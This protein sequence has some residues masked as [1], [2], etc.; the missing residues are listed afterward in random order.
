MSDQRDH[1][2]RRRRRWLRTALAGLLALAAC[3]LVTWLFVVPE[4][5]RQRIDRILGTIEPGQRTFRLGSIDPSSLNVTHVALG[6]R[7]WLTI[8]RIQARY[9][10]A[11]LWRGELLAVEVHEPVWRIA[12]H[13]GGIDWGFTPPAQGASGPVAAPFH[14]LSVREGEV[15]VESDGRVLTAPVTV[16]AAR[17]G[18]GDFRGQVET[19]EI[20]V[21]RHALPPIVAAFAFDG[22]LLD[23]TAAWA[24]FAEAP[25]TGRAQLDLSGPHPA[26]SVEVHQPTVALAERSTLQDLVPALRDVAIAGRFALDAEIRLAGGRMHPLVSLR[27][28]EVMLASDDWPIA[29]AS[30]SGILDFD[31]LAPLS[32]SGPQRIRI[33]SATTG[34]LE[35]TAGQIDFNL[36][37]P[38][39]LRIDR[40]Q[41]VMSDGGRFE[42]AAFTLDPRQPRIVTSIACD[43]VDLSF[44]LDFLTRERADGEG[45]LRGSFD[46]D[47]NPQSNPR[48]QFTGGALAA[49]PPHGFIRV[50]D[51]PALGELLEQADA[52]F[53]IDETMQRVKE[54]IVEALQDLGYTSLRFVFIPDGPGTTLQAEIKGRGRTGQRQEFEGLVV[55]FR[56]FAHQLQYALGAQ[57]A[58]DSVRDLRDETSRSRPPAIGSPLP[59]SP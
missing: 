12:A 17:A 52:R 37:S 44:W 42:A 47:W 31:A 13:D 6:R 1:P 19:G 2:P 59:D 57:A 29:I 24:L 16:S 53:S 33:A 38:D 7:P 22:R 54:R 9:S 20:A 18:A 25:A 35:F 58:V 8:D 36:D 10:L 49:H 51:A 46:I 28:T 27:A 21:D 11:S 39:A 40:A 4:I 26:G 56:R 23:V 41:W 32:T 15:I 14:A 48:L 5:V 45:R 34:E 50:H 30:A 43:N 3:L 55:N